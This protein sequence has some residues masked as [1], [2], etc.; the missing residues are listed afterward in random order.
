MSQNK[1]S[2]IENNT[3]AKLNKLS[4]LILSYNQ[5]QCLEEMAFFGLT[6]LRILSLHSN[7]LSFLPENAFTNVINIS[8]IALGSN[9]LYCDC[10]MAWFS[11]WIKARFVEPGIAKC[12][13][14]I[15]LKN[16][17]LLTANQ[18]QFRLFFKLIILIY[19]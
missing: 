2:I 4:T 13:L 12:D 5:L 7:N 11:K 18:N 14:P 19:F 15:E 9:T 1:I 10:K 6:N 8:H 16:Q 17:L 3:F